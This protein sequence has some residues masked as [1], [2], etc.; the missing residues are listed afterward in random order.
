MSVQMQNPAKTQSRD[1]ESIIIRSLAYHGELGHADAYDIL[2]IVTEDD[3][4]TP[5][6]ANQFRALRLAWDGMTNAEGV[7]HPDDTKHL[8]EI[9]VASFLSERGELQRIGGRE[10]LHKLYLNAGEAWKYDWRRSVKIV[11][12]CTRKRKVMA[13]A[14]M[15]LQ[16]GGQS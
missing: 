14:A 15:A 16:G 11:E 7:V 1:D 8:D 6:H 5:A 2:E 12:E 3:F 10:A 9:A 13:D 4:V